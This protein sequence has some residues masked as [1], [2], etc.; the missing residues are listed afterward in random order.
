MVKLTWSDNSDNEIGFVI[1]RKDDVNIDWAI[2]DTL[3]ENTIELYDSN[4]IV[5][6]TYEW[7]IYS[8]NII[9]NSPYSNVVSTLITSI[10][11]E[12]S[13]PDDYSLS[14]NYPNPFNPTTKINFDIPKQSYVKLVIYDL[15]GMEVSTLVNSQLNPGRYSAEWNGSDLASGMYFY[16]IEA[17]SFSQIK[18]MVLIK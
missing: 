6:R 5:G 4:L 16:K 18:K 15:L 10:D 3:S 12:A 1:E 2:L 8:Y 11:P 17:G 14:Q 13:I 9:G 7:R